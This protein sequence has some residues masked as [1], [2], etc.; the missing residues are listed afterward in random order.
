MLGEVAKGSKV[1]PG[2]QTFPLYPDH[3]CLDGGRLK[4]ILFLE[5]VGDGCSHS[6]DI[7]DEI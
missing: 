2:M 4:W 3:L 1:A 7:F 6:P 5:G